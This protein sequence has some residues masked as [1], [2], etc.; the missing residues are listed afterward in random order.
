MALLTV[1]VSP[2]G[3]VMTSDSQPVDLHA[4]NRYV[5]TSPQPIENPIVQATFNSFAG[6]AGHVGT[7]QLLGQPTRYWLEQ[8]VAAN[9][10]N[11]L[12][13]AC[14]TMAEELTAIW[15]TQRLE[16]HL[17]LFLAGFENSEA[18]FWYIG[19]GGFPSGEPQFPRAFT[20]VD[21]LDGNWYPLHAE[22]DETKAQLIIRLNPSF[23]RGVLSAALLFD[24]FTELIAKSLQQGHPEFFPLDS[25]DRYAAYTRRRFEFTKRMYD[26]KYS[27]GIVPLPPI[28]GEIRVVSIDASAVRRQ[29]GKHV[30]QQ[31]ILG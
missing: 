5:I 12:D 19:N 18:R 29:H 2:F 15:Q 1:D 28:R 24:S 6:F 30:T 13:V 7:S 21:D 22:P 27:F 17:S 20:A 8:A 11:D 9:T 3:I 23:R 16:T 25:L 26:P 4:P 31:R 10:A 14:Q